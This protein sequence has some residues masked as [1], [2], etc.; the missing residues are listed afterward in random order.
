MGNWEKGDRIL[1][2]KIKSILSPF[3]NSSIQFSPALPS[4]QIILSAPPKSAGNNISG[5]V[6]LRFRWDSKESKRSNRTM[7]GRNGFRG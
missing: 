5:S 4:L 3:V 1:L 6:S 7:F 2:L